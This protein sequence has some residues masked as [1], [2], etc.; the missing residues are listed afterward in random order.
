MDAVRLIGATRHA[1]ARS[2]A[3]E[4]I[5]AESWQAQALAQAV[6]N[7]LAV[8]GPAELR[9]EATGL[10]EAGG[11]ACRVLHGSGAERV[12]AAQLSEVQDPWTALTGLG[13]LLG[14]VGMALVRV[15]CAAEDE[16]LYWQC[17]EAIDAADESS[18]RVRG[19]LRQLEARERGQPDS[20]AR[21][22]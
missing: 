11:R 4:D 15:A 3:A 1:L 22:P 21:P 19:L 9:S 7:H 10:S 13:G 20:V 6:G 12:R 5:V 18:D 16:T 17:I 14:E 2:L 8:N